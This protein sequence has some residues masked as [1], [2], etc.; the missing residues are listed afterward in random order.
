LVKNP[1]AN[2]GNVGDEGS[3][4]GLGRYPGRGKW[5]YTLVFLPKNIPWTEKPGQ[6]SS[7]G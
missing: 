6:L 7:W 3:I 5:Q 4:A 1:P 2:A